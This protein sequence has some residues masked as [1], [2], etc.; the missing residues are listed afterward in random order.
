[1]RWLILIHAGGGSD[2]TGKR[3]EK[4][5]AKINGKID[6]I[7]LFTLLGV[8][9]RQPLLHL[10]KRMV[11]LFTIKKQ[12]NQLFNWLYDRVQSTIS[13]FLKSYIS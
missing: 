2:R 10:S 5:Q 13:K 7:P 6:F 3:K 1:M 8:N 11:Y 9:H 12:I 4:Y